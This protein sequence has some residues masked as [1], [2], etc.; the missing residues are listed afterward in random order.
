LAEQGHWGDAIQ[1]ASQIQLGR[2]LYGEAQGAI[3]EWQGDQQPAPV[4]ETWTEPSQRAVAPAPVE[5]PP[6]EVAPGEPAAVAVSQPE[7][8]IASPEPPVEVAPEVEVPAAPSEPSP[9]FEGFYDQ[10]YFDHSQ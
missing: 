1:K 2:A 3:A 5:P 9:S 8:A 10:R 4:E 7:E 6:L